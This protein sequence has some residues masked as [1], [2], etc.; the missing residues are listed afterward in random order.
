MYGP[1]GIT[2]VWQIQ[3]GVRVNVDDASRT[4]SAKVYEITPGN[5]EINR[6]VQDG[7]AWFDPGSRVKVVAEAN[8][9]GQNGL[10]LNGWEKWS[11]PRSQCRADFS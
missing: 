10:S 4:S 9:G 11:P 3:Y 5:V 1:G 7:V 2:Y 6:T 8:E